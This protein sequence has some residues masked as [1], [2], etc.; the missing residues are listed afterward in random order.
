MIR[1]ACQGW[2]GGGGTRMLAID[3]CRNN[4]PGCAKALYIYIYIYTFIGI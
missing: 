3:G 4:L 2:W 1:N